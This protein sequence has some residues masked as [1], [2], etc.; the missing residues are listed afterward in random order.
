MPYRYKV[1]EAVR[2]D[3]TITTYRAYM[4]Y[5]GEP[6]DGDTDD[7]TIDSSI[8][9]LTEEQDS[10]D[11]NDDGYG[12]SDDDEVEYLTSIG[13]PVTVKSHKPTTAL[14]QP[15]L[16]AAPATIPTT[17]LKVSKK[18]SKP[19]ITK[20][21]VTPP[22][23]RSSHSSQT[24]AAGVAPVSAS[25]RRKLTHSSAPPPT[26]AACSLSAS[27]DL[28]TVSS[29]SP[30]L[31]AP[32]QPTSSPRRSTRIAAR[33]AARKEA[34]EDSPIEASPKKK[35]KASASVRPVPAAA[36]R[37]AS[38]A[39]APARSRLFRRLKGSVTSA[40]P[41][42]S[43]TT[44]APASHAAPARST[45]LVTRDQRILSQPARA[46]SPWRTTLI[47]QPHPSSWPTTTP[48]TLAAARA[49]VSALPIIPVEEEEDGDDEG[50]EDDHDGEESM[51]SSRYYINS[52]GNWS[53]GRGG[54]NSEDDYIDYEG[55]MRQQ[56]Y[57]NNRSWY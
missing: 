51:D 1:E 20:L 46:I 27:R 10:D 36:A 35:C 53:D 5:L 54:Y 13:R 2:M 23:I 30:S 29:S 39:P 12:N 37:A 18:K 48:P 47:P 44:T 24:A 6:C 31:P 9:D 33:L 42:Q 45:S 41:A 56:D 50:H 17:S 57:W 34:K 38:T 8:L 21:S 7:S 52:D 19:A 28:R 3:E 14:L 16:A 25:G 49:S 4:R 22:P 15:T 26:P 40:Q 11:D 32:V 43:V 55:I